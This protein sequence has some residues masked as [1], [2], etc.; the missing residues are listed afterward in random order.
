MLDFYDGNIVV[1]NDII[2]KGM[3]GTIK[4]VLRPVVCSS[5][6]EMQRIIFRLS[7][8]WK[9]TIRLRTPRR[10]EMA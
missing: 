5:D 10:S 2:F 8:I 4:E 9:N 3:V 6:C 1:I 7:W